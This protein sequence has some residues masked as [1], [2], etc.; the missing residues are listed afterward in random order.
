M[1]KYFCYAYVY[2][3]YTTLIVLF[4]LANFDNKATAIYYSYIHNLSLANLH[5]SALI[6]TKVTMTMTNQDQPPIA[7]AIRCDK[8]YRFSPTESKQVVMYNLHIIIQLYNYT[9]TELLLPP[10]P[11]SPS[12]PSQDFISSHFL[13]CHFCAGISILS[14]PC[15]FP[16]S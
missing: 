7:D 6:S 5:M 11:S 10:S 4:T 16:L 8:T 2:V 3:S 12:S 13:I 1:I 15:H 14:A 9:I